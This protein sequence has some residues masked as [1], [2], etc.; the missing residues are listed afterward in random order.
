M[1]G[2]VSLVP[3]EVVLD[4]EDAK[5]SVKVSEKEAD[6]VLCVESVLWVELA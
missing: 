5:L 6:A 4:A 1:L 2:A 3:V